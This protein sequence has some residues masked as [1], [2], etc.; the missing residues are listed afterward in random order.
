MADKNFEK[1]IKNILLNI[2]SRNL[3][4]AIFIIKKCNF[5]NEETLFK[6]LRRTVRFDE[7]DMELKDHLIYLLCTLLL[8]NINRNKTND[9][10]TNQIDQILLS[11]I[12][13]SK[14][15]N[16]FRDQWIN[17]KNKFFF[18]LIIKNFKFYFENQP[19]ILNLFDSEGPLFTYLTYL[20]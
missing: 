17:F 4:S 18:K 12:L 16:L 15:L 9:N 14:T 19:Q 13:G 8:K 10:Q 7:C 6:I 2:S 11:T 3:K 5:H 1:E 20:H